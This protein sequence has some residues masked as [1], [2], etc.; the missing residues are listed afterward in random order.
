M[1]QSKLPN[2]TK[3]K[4]IVS[5]QENNKL[6][7]KKRNE[8]FS[9]TYASDEEEIDKELEEEPD[10]EETAEEPE[11]NDDEPSTDIYIGNEERE[12]DVF[13]TSLEEDE[14]FSPSIKKVVLIIEKTS[15]GYRCF[16]CG[17]INSFILKES[18]NMSE[19]AKEKHKIECE[20]FAV[21]DRVK[22]K[23]DCFLSGFY[24][25]ETLDILE[26]IPLFKSEEVCKGERNYLEKPCI[27]LNPNKDGRRFVFPFNILTPQ[28][29]LSAEREMFVWFRNYLSSAEN[30]EKFAEFCRLLNLNEELADLYKVN[31]K[32]K[33]F[34]DACFWGK[35]PS[36]IKKFMKYPAFKKLVLTLRG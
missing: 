26:L 3:V 33:D 2:K 4:K 30:K 24:N 10:Q 13:S 18:K 27:M 35:T 16:R 28:G 11:I 34:F 32:I 8:I 25:E 31:R 20:K 15:E 6:R 9:P 22:E 12:T 29:K 1:A 21:I 17:F 19:K 23:I 14:L 36:V 5:V 7:V